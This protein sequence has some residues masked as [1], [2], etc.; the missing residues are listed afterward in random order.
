M[1]EHT[2]KQLDHALNQG[3]IERPEF[4][5][6]FLSKIKFSGEG[7]MSIWSRANHPWGK[8]KLEL[9]NAENG[10]I[11]IIERE[12]ETDVLVVF[13]V[14]PTRRIAL[15]IEK[16]LD[17]GSFTR[18]QPE[19]YATRAESWKDNPKY[20]NYE[21]WD[22]VLVAPQ[23]FYERNTKDAKKF[24]LFIFHEEIASLIPDF[25]SSQ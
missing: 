4:T 1:T 17:S 13:E 20:A 3:F 7:A 8:V 15:H 14:N 10:E 24:G 5:Q 25:S 22:T 9:L 2:E 18:L 19:L 11:E 23:S 16:K 12:C 21:D 6:W